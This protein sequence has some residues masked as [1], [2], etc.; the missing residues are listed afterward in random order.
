MRT[1][2]TT[3]ATAAIAVLLAVGAAHSTANRYVEQPDIL[4]QTAA[5]DAFPDA[6]YGVDP[7]VTGPTSAAFATKQTELG[8]DKATWPDI[9]LGC[10]PDR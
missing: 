1:L 10:Y 2:Q 9:P 7:M 4:L 6:A 3:L 5:E 8:C